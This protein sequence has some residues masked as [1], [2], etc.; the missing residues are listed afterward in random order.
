VH[1]LTEEDWRRHLEAWKEIGGPQQEYCKQHGLTPWAFSYW[2]RK[3]GYLKGPRKG[4]KSRLVEVTPIAVNAPAPH[5]R[6]HPPLFALRV[7]ENGH[8]SLELRIRGFRLPWL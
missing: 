1:Q 2:K 8:L 3:L 6:S 5:A 7:E 4:R